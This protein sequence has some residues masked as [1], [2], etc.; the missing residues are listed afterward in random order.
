VKEGLEQLSCTADVMGSI[1]KSGDRVY[2]IFDIPQIYY[3][4]QKIWIRMRT[5]VAVL[6]R[7]AFFYSPGDGKEILNRLKKL[8]EDPK[9]Q[10]NPANK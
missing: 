3:D 2:G 9:T 4:F 1:H 10:K 5:K 8:N 6:L 7:S